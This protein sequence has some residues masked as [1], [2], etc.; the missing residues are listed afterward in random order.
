MCMMPCSAYN[1]T[2]LIF[3]TLDE[4]TEK[5]AGKDENILNKLEQSSSRAGKGNRKKCGQPIHIVKLIWRFIL[6]R[7]SYVLVLVAYIWTNAVLEQVK[8]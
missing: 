5:F 1:L 7:R 8:Q 3:L 2:F 6:G 4:C